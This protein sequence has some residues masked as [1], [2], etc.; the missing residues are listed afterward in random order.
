MMILQ[1]KCRYQVT[2]G[3]D[4]CETAWHSPIIEETLETVSA[5]SKRAFCPQ[6]TACAHHEDP[7]LQVAPIILNVE[8]IDNEFAIISLF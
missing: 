4:I 5:M 7:D 3:C 6:C 1:C 8:N 2:L